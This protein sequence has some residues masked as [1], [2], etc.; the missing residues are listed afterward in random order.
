VYSL[1]ASSGCIHWFFQAAAGVRSAITIARAG[2]RDLAFFGDQTGNAYALD[3][4]TGAVIWKT[5]VD[6]MPITRVSGSPAFYNGRLYVPVASGEEGAG[7]VPTYECC[8]F[9]GSVVALDAATGRQL[10]KTYT[11]AEE[12][13]P[14]TKN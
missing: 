13:K 14:T 9:R 8:K 10:W 4:A 7:S 11:I 5:R 6:A 1:N 3:A 2:S 12:P